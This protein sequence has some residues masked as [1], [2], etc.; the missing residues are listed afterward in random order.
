[1][2]TFL[3]AKIVNSETTNV[4]GQTLGQIFC[5]P[6]P[7]N[8][9]TSLSYMLYH[10]AVLHIEVINTLQQVVANLVRHEAREAGSYLLTV[11]VQTL[12]QGAYS[13]R[14]TVQKS[15]GQQERKNVALII[16]R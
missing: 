8:E 4:A 11:P 6:N 12:P 3:R 9:Q 1:M 10:D 15:N 14:V 2:P 5:S 13:V 7:A 16:Q